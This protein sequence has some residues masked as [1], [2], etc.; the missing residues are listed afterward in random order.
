MEIPLNL[1][2]SP[3]LKAYACAGEQGSRG[4]ALLYETLRERLRS[5]TGEQGRVIVQVLSPLPLPSSL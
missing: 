1:D 3:M 2:F 4:A 5:V